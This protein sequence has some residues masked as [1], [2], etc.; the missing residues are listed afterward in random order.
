[1]N[2]QS[3]LQ[4]IKT[5]CLSKKNYLLFGEEDFFIDQIESY[6]LK[7][8]IPDSDKSFNQ[9]TFYGKDT[10]VFSLIGA[11]KSFPMIGS[12]QLLVLKDADKM[13]KIN[14]LE[15][16]LHNPVETS[17]FVL[18][19]KK[20]NIDRRKKWVKLFQNTGLLIESKKIYGSQISKWID[21]QL[22]EKNIKIDKSAE[23]L[24]INQLGTDLSKLSNSIDKLSKIVSDGIITASDVQEHI[25]IH[26]EYNNF[27]LQNALAEKDKNKIIS[28]VNYFSTNP[29]KFPLI[30]I[31]GILFSFFSKLI[32]IHTLDSNSEK[33]IAEKIKVHPFFISTYKSACLNYSFEDC[34]RIISLLKEYDL[35]C[36]G[37]SGSS[38]D[39]LLEG[40]I[41][42]ILYA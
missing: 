25:G 12:Q 33:Y 41:I 39:H 42:D 17:I 3:I 29:N 18:S 38:T 23:K 4:S 35:R 14:E 2:I 37:I 31:V 10:N 19:Y 21:N 40:L 32:I 9:K 13:D 20:K 6:F 7:Y 30:S 16:Y 1:M 34:I 5:Q 26:R 11:L 8:T 22:S 27:E 15:Q 36:K 28:I 24:L